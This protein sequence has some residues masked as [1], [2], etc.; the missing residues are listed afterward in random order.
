MDPT[1][2]L[3]EFATYIKMIL[4]DAKPQLGVVDVFYGDQRKIPRTPTVCVEP[5]G[6]DREYAGAPRAVMNTLELVILVYHMRIAD[7]QS[8][9]EEVD[10]IAED[11]EAFLHNDKTVNG[12]AIDS[13]VTSMDSG[14]AVRAN[15]LFRTTRLTF[16]MRSK[17]YLPLGGA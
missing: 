6:K 5:G 7:V 15:T 17:T 14:Y 3:V 2:S 10:T 1:D 13:L 9:R 16:Q 4:D 11:V 12:L 8:V